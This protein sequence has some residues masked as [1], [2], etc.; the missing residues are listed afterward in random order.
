VAGGDREVVRHP[1][2][3]GVLAVTPS[4]DVL[5]VRQ[6]RE[7]VRERLLE[8]PA[9]LRDVD[10]EPPDACAARELLEETGHR[11]TAIHPMGTLLT[12]PGFADER[13]ELFT[14]TATESPVARPTEEGIEL[15]RMPLALAVRAVTDGR[16]VDA[17]TAVAV[18][19]ATW[20][21]RLPAPKA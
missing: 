2:A 3:S 7:P 21:E 12:S 14:A 4:G 13:I 9:G 1:G 19:L 6:V 18:L 11:A 10:G 15:V 16:I 5:L 8:I 17:K 20:G